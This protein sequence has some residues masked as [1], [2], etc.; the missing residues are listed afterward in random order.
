MSNEAVYSE[1][2]KVDEATTPPVEQSERGWFDFMKTKKTDE[3]TKCDD[4]D[5]AIS[6][7][8]DQ[9]VHVSDPEPKLAEEEHKHE[10]SFEKMSTEAEPKADEKP[11]ET[12]FQKMSEAEPE[13][14]ENKHETLLQKMHD[15]HVGSSSGSSSDE[16][17]EDG[18]K[19]KK[20]KKEK[21][22]M[23][24]QIQEKIEER[25]EKKEEEEMAK[26]ENETHVPVEKY[27]EVAAPPH[28]SE[29][30]HPIVTPEQPH[31]SEVAHP[32]ATPEPEEKKGFME[33]LKDKLPGHKKVE[34]EE[35]SA[36]PPST[37]AVETYD[38]EEKEKKGIFKKIKE[39]I[40]GYHSKA[41]GE[42]VKECD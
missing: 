24:T 6:S 11:Y 20:K 28:I 19:K 4:E 10:T 22:S 7:E 8:F 1:S 25:K 23:T 14:D 9:K 30:A 39:K 2:P 35:H 29:V 13:A 12:L 15:S 5:A 17:C 21:K 38:G 3:G 37:P 16:E 27:E 26:H 40:P 31:T 41:E 18:E 33:K 32:I 42:M 36:P 34:E